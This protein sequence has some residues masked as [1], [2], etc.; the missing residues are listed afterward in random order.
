[1]Y[2]AFKGF[3]AKTMHY[4]GTYII[5]LMT[6]REKRKCKELLAQQIHA[7]MLEDTD[8]QLTDK[9][10]EALH[11]IESSALVFTAF[12]NFQQYKLMDVNIT[13][14]RACFVIGDF[15]LLENEDR[16]GFEVRALNGADPDDIFMPLVR[17]EFETPHVV[18]IPNPTMIP[19]KKST[20]VCAVNELCKQKVITPEYS[21]CS[22]CHSYNH[23]TNTIL[24]S[25]Q[26]SRDSDAGLL[27][28]YAVEFRPEPT[29]YLSAF[30]STVVR[31][32]YCLHDKASDSLASVEKNEADGAE[33]KKRQNRAMKHI[34]YIHT[35]IEHYSVYKAKLEEMIKNQINTLEL[36]IEVLNV[37][38]QQAT[39]TGAPL[40]WWAFWRSPKDDLRDLQDEIDL[41]KIKKKGITDFRKKLQANDYRVKDAVN[42]VVSEQTEGSR[43]FERKRWCWLG[44]K[45]TM[46]N[47][48]R[49]AYL[50]RAAQQQE[51]Q[52][53]AQE[54]GRCDA[55]SVLRQ[56][57]APA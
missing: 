53:L 21:G 48:S 20:A 40:H 33:R 54:L 24:I 37:K 15:A 25:N 23:D 17:D 10:K 12:R 45:C 47:S 29:K 19:S 14:E 7:R 1:M 9:E 55:I 8:Y 51:T 30:A 6:L 39:E 11:E 16:D 41:K 2:T 3:Q 13:K 44:S 35:C 32:F 27:S 36:E 28:Q 5:H 50:L 46:F 57:L 34:G 42:Q 18:E 52:Y 49:T 4:M 38:N 56:K 31:N 43:L 22:R 26:M